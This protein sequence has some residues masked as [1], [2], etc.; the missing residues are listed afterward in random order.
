[1]PL[2]PKRLEPGKTI[3][4]IAPASAPGSDRLIKSGIKIMERR[5]YKVKMGKFSRAAK[6]FL[7]G[8]DKQRLSDLH[9]MFKDPEVDAIICLRGGYGATRLLKKIDYQLIRRNPKIFVGF[10]DITGLAMAFLKKANLV[11]FHGPMITSNIAHKNGRKYTLGTL[12]DMITKP[13][14]FGS[15][16]PGSGIRRGKTLR[17]GRAS[18]ALVGGNLSLLTTL[19]GT[20]WEFSTQNKIVFIEE[21]GEANYRIDRMFTHLLNAGKLADAAGIVL[22]Y[23]SD[24]EIK[25][26]PDDK[27]TQSLEEIF[28]DRL[29]SLN[30]PIA[31]GFPFG[32]EKITATLPVGVKATLDASK[33]DLIIEEKAVR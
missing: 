17:R 4:V 32:H 26:G 12:M 22:G 30:I 25:P 10:S 31:Y 5:G 3:G 6:G 14:P 15:I 27:P 11:T 13:E 33:G 24:T 8:T 19:L 2:K 7:A 9:A 1:M 16:L 28:R 21:V 29:R 23:F 20:P 18:G